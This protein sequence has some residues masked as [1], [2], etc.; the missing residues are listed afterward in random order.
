MKTHS[1]YTEHTDVLLPTLHF[2]RTSHKMAT[3]HNVPADAPSRHPTIC[4]IS[5]THDKKMVAHYYEWP[6][7]PPSEPSG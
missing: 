5:Y 3:I 7:V 6:D 1:Q 2:L 4:K